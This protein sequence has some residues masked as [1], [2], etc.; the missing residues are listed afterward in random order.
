MNAAGSLNRNVIWARGI[1]LFNLPKFLILIFSLFAQIFNLYFILYFILTIIFYFD[2]R[3]K[4]RRKLRN[5][6][7]RTYSN[8]RGAIHRDAP[9]RCGTQMCDAG[10]GAVR[11]GVR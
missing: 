9:R 5:V 2:D 6:L 3:R 7:S 4:L 1:F 10:G 8:H 11:G